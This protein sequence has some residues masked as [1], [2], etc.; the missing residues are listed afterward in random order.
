M[1]RCW[2]YIR[3]SSDEQAR[4][5]MSLIAQ[6]D[7]CLKHA[8]SKGYE[9]GPEPADGFPGVF[10]DPGVSAWKGS[11]WDRPGWKALWK[12]VQDGDVIIV[13]S[14]DRGWRN[15]MDMLRSYELMQS[16]GVTMEFVQGDFNIN[17]AN[18]KFLLTMHGAFAQ[19][20][21]D[22]ASER[23][24]EGMAYHKALREEGKKPSRKK[25]ALKS[26][27]KPVEREYS[28]EWLDRS[29]WGIG[30]AKLSNAHEM[31]DTTRK[32]R[33]YGYVRVSTS[34][35][36]V[37]SQRKPVTG[38]MTHLSENEGLS[39]GEVYSDDGV[40]AYRTPFVERP[41]GLAC[42]KKLQ[43]GDHLVVARADRLF[44]SL[45]DM[46]IQ[47]E[48]FRQLGVTVHFVHDCIRT[49]LAGGNQM[50][51]ML[52]VVAKWES[53]AVR[54]A[55]LESFAVIREQY[56][57]SRPSHAPSWVRPVR[58]KGHKRWHYQFN[59]Q[60]LEDIQLAEEMHRGGMTWTRVSDHLEA[61]CAEREQRAPIPAAGID[62]F[63]F[64]R[65][66]RR[67]GCTVMPGTLKYNR[68]YAA[69]DRKG[70]MGEK[71][72]RKERVFIRRPYH[73]LQSILPAWKKDLRRWLDAH[74]EA[75]GEHMED[76][77][78]L[79]AKPT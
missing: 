31:L 70:G 41:A 54:T 65:K 21:S 14:L 50:I 3:V 47:M 69:Q 20:K 24:R 73:H 67:E 78:Q 79:V 17:S 39:L 71:T 11:I 16:A 12:N 10:C 35:Q 18:G 1:T 28:P 27:V 26:K 76:L 51:D 30:A 25:V 40:S 62:R 53:E 46:S 38:W 55:T 36:S 49:D 75:F 22:L 77:R 33:V 45:H 72:K 48:A 57:W 19:L 2:I 58:V 44:R 56:G 7:L 5:G 9:L 43:R 34:D 32:G 42:W 61:Y 66:L 60:W 74:P 64:T 63:M 59:V 29:P 68:W 4:E 8:A 52:G 23:V 6:R 15:T 13:K 37:N